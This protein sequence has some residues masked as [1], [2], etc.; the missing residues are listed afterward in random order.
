[1]KKFLWWLWAAWLVPMQLFAWTNG[2]L[3]IWMDPDRGHA[4]KRMAQK[5]HDDLG[6]DATIETPQNMTD[7]FPLAAQ[8]GKGPDIVIWAHDKVGEWADG[9][10]IAPITMSEAFA[11][12]FFPKARQA[13]LHENRTWGYPIALETVTLIYNGRLLDGHPPTEL[14]QLVS[15]NQKVQSNHPGV[16]TIL[17]DYK[18]A[19]YS[20]GILDSAGGYV[21]GKKGTD[22][23]VN[24]VGV[25]TAGCV[26]GLSEIIAL[27]H[28]GILPKSVSYSTIEDLMV[29]DKLAM[30]I[31]GPWAWSNLMQSGI[32]FRVAPVPGVNG[33]PGRPFV[34][35]TVAYV[36]R[37]S[38]NHDLVKEFLEGYVLTDEGIT[39]M[40]N[41]KPLGVPA[42]IS[43]YTS[44][45]KGNTRL[46][47]LK[48]C[49]DYG[50]V[51]P[52]IPQMG[53]FFS[54]MGPALQIATEG[55][56][57]AQASLREAEANM[58]RR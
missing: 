34:G 37:S 55:R 57:S 29:R 23:D 39:A 4:L 45:A 6:I 44:M 49:V 11:S 15:V 31:S 33:K 30:M 26:E 40:N 27:V 41:A 7:S 22:Y 52:N 5:F 20:W 32:E 51:T 24:D 42:L 58:R 14:S 53:R 50:Q 12:K 47:Q 13:V 36:N 48:T 35:V 17:W 28:A 38:P 54:A 56:A 3:L 43:L 21:F 25:A 1:M 18:S 46:Q 2:E 19:Y 8:V 16:T 9:G 10:L